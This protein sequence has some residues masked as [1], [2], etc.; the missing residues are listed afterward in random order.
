MVGGF[1]LQKTYKR[2]ALRTF[3]LFHFS[4]FFFFLL[5]I[6]TFGHIKGVSL[7]IKIMHIVPVFVSWGHHLRQALL[8]MEVSCIPPPPKFNFNIIMSCTIYFS[9]YWDVW[10]ICK[11]IIMYLSFCHNI[12]FVCF[13]L[14]LYFVI[15][16]FN[17]IWKN[18]DTNSNSNAY[19][20]TFAMPSHEISRN[21]NNNQYLYSA[22]SK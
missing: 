1:N 11:Q 22:F 18:A 14:F 6:S 21:N 8:M 7:L 5:L 10:L 16:F 15:C 20:Q 2:A 9:I 13:K 4:F 3:L 17:Y 12:Y 19:E